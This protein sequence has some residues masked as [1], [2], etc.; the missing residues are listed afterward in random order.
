MTTRAIRRRWARN[1]RAA[2]G[3]LGRMTYGEVH[4]FLRRAAQHGE[5][6][7]DVNGNPIRPQ[8]AN[9]LELLAMVDLTVADLRPEPPS[10]AFL[11]WRRKRGRA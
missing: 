4:T 9:V 2:R 3:F 11:R 10:V 5:T 6:W 8:P 1:V 7:W